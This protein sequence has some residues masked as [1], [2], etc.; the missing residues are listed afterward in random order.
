MQILYVAFEADPFVKTGGLGDV[1][2]SLPP[3]IRDKETE[4]RVILPKH[5]AID[6]QWGGMMKP[7]FSGTVQLGWRNQYCGIEE[8]QYKGIHYYFVDN[9]YYFM[10]DP[11][12]GY[13][14]DGERVSF[15]CRA[16]LEAIQDFAHTG[17][18]HP[19]ILHCNDW[20]AALIPVMLRENYGEDPLYKNIKTVFTIHNLKYQGIY[21]HAL[22]NDMLHL[23]GHTAAAGNL[24]YNGCLNFMKGGILYS[25]KITTVSPSY[26]KE[27]Q[28]AYYGEGL[29]GILRDR[30]AD[31]KG[32][33]NGIDTETYDPENDPYLYER[34][35][36]DF[37]MK[38]TNKKELQN[39]LSLRSEATNP[40]F[41][42]ISRLVEQ[43]GLDLLAHILEEFLQED[44]QFI[45][46]GT[47]EKK[48]E[49]MFHHYAWKYNEKMRALMHFDNAMAHK[50][51]AAGDVLVMPSQFEPCGISQMIAMRYGALPLV[52]ET[53]GLK[54]SVIPYTPEREDGDGFAFSN[55]NAHE[56]LFMMKDA[57]ALYKN[58]PELWRKL[59]SNGYRRDCSWKKSAAEYKVLYRELLYPKSSGEK[60]NGTNRLS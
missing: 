43:K 44:I 42:V 16:V 29:D 41:V 15:F 37:K 33:L 7:L 22:L 35:G 26:A 53:G 27:I 1:A 38:S 36:A 4:I 25:D 10:R 9:E 12:Y 49:G 57:A 31:L 54:D 5:Q 17:D 21:S 23:A 48:Y 46:L 13:D 2:G 8:M 34:Y 47:G 52:R 18:F 40:L 60:R 30:S 11:I 51:Y 39:A 14:D 20:H 3:S 19:E 58:Q 59:M 6:K 28:T 50:L 32:I 45:I 56:L 55:Y 24:D